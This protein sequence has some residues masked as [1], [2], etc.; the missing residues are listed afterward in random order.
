MRE[1][2]LRSPCVVMTEWA[3]TQ[4]S[5]E[6]CVKV[7]RSSASNVLGD[8]GPVTTFKG[9]GFRDFVFNRLCGNSGIKWPRCMV[10]PLLTTIRELHPDDKELKITL[11]KIQRESSQLEL[12]EIPPLVYQLLLLS[13]H[14]QRQN[15][16]VSFCFVLFRQVCSFVA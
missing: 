14:G 3:L 1:G 4:V 6:D 7:K 11:R 16:L 8:D 2:A 13:T 10:V 15:I 5:K 12:Q 9:S